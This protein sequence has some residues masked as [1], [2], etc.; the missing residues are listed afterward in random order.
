[1]F[2]RWSRKLTTAKLHLPY[3]IGTGSQQGLE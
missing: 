1:L 2:D 3:K